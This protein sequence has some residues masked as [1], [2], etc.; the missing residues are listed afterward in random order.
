MYRGEEA[1]GYR[2]VG[3]LGSFVVSSLRLVK[4]RRNE[5]F[6]F[7]MSVKNMTGKVRDARRVEIVQDQF[8]VYVVIVRT[9]SRRRR[10]HSRCATIEQRWEG[11]DNDLC[12]RIDTRDRVHTRRGRECRGRS[13]N[14]R[15]RCRRSF[16]SERRRHGRGRVDRNRGDVVKVYVVVV[17]VQVT[18]IGKP[19]QCF[20]DVEK[21]VDVSSLGIPRRHVLVRIDPVSDSGR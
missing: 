9:S 5:L 19:I 14:C 20:C 6:L 10:L 16:W 12:P 15:S 1:V 2:L 17:L 13:S 4:D 21:G 7:I 8:I 3:V 18:S 11:R